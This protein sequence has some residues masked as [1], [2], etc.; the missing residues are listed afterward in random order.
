MSRMIGN[1]KI[2]KWELKIQWKGADWI[3]IPHHSKVTTKPSYL[4]LR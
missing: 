1:Y 3:S 4:V 2:N